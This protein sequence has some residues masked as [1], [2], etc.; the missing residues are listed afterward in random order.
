M[1]ESPFTG[2]DNNGLMA[3]PNAAKALIIVKR[4]FAANGLVGQYDLPPVEGLPAHLR[5][6][7]PG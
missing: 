4:A 7:F 5:G 2:M 6:Q 1:A 3:L